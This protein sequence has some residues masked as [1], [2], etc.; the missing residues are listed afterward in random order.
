VLAYLTNQLLHGVHALD[1]E[2]AAENE[3]IIF[4]LPRPKRD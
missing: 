1:R 2:D 3:T 4:D